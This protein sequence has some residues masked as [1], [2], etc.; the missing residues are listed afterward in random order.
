MDEVELKKYVI[1][2]MTRTKVAFLTTI[3]K[4]GLPHIRAIDNLRNP[5]RFP[6]CSKV[7]IGS[8]DSFLVY[9]STN[10]SSEKVKQINNNNNIA[11]YYCISEEIKGVMVRG[12]AEIVD[13]YEIKKKIWINRMKIYY[14]KGVEDPDFTLIRLI[15]N[16]I[17]A[18]NRLHNYI[19]DL[20]K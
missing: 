16:Y 20:R 1:D 18:Y 4:E 19:I 10:T 14:P 8:D 7:F 15:P 3:D 12:C 13:G 2:L 6:H 5:K 11:L 17:K 9:I